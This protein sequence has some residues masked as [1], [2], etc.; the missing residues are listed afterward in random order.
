MVLFV[1]EE[2][3]I[4]DHMVQALATKPD[5]LCLIPGIHTVGEEN[6]LLECESD[7]NKSL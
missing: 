4:S 6:Q 5:E 3:F 7:L 1:S 2:L